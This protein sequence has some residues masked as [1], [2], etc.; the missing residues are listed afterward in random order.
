[1]GVPAD[2]LA[3]LVAV[4]ARR[5]GVD[6]T[7]HDVY[8]SLAG[9]ASVEEPALDLAVAL[10]LASTAQ[11]RTI[12]PGTVACGEVTLLGGLRPVRGLERRLREAARL[13]F[14]RAIV[15][16][17]DEAERLRGGVPGSSGTLE[18]IA[19]ATLRDALSVSAAAHPRVTPLASEPVPLG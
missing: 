10:A 13:G 8:L 2:R 7:R 1:V 16:A 14:R 19:V 9:G 11:D 15:P 6:V 12:D 4:L 18:V 3:L 17:G 5:C